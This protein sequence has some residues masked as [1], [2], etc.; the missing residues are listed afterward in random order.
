MTKGTIPVFEYQLLETATNKFSESNVLS[1]GS[2]G[3]LY[4]ACLDEKSSVTVKKL[5][6]G[7]GDTDIEKQ[8]EVFN[9]LEPQRF[10]PYTPIKVISFY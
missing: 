8:F 2:R 9:R 6:D 5:D 7:G 10:L 1:R 3:C 4:R